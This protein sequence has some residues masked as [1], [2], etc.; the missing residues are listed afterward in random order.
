MAFWKQCFAMHKMLK[1]CE[2]RNRLHKEFQ[3]TRIYE[4]E[5]IKNW[6]KTISN[7]AEFSAA[8]VIVSQITKEN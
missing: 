4:T 6:V 3:R 2:L 7:T 1:V 5:Q 8:F